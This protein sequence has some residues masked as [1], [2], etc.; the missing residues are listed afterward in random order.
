MK[1]QITHN[2]FIVFSA[3][4]FSMLFGYGASALVAAQY[5]SAPEVDAFFIALPLPMIIGYFILSVALVALVPHYQRLSSELG[6]HQAQR[7]IAPLFWASALLTL[8]ISV[9]LFFTGE[10]VATALAPGF[11]TQRHQLLAGYLQ[12]MSL[13][14]PFLALSAFLQAIENANNRFLR[15]AFARPLASG[16]ALGVL[17][18][19]LM[20]ASL[21]Y[22]FWGLAAGAACAF[23]WQLKEAYRF[24]YMPV[25]LVGLPE[26]WRAVRGSAGW[27]ALARAMAHASG[28]VLQMIASLAV[29]GTVAVYGFGFKIAAIPLLLSVSL[30]MVLFP[31]QTLANAERN[32]RQAANILW[33]GVNSLFILGALFGSFFFLW[34]D[35][36]VILFYE[37][38]DFDPAL[39]ESVASVIR[40]FSLGFVAV[41]ANNTIGNAFWAAGRLK[42]R[43]ALEVVGLG[44]L[45]IG[46]LALIES[47]GPVGLALAYIAMFTFL[48][49]IGLWRLNPE[50]GELAR[51]LPTL[52]KISLTAVALALAASPAT[53]SPADF[54]ELDLF[55]R[56]G[57]IGGSFVG[58][59]VA[60][61]LALWVMRVSE[62]RE[63]IARL[64]DMAAKLKRGGTPGDAAQPPETAPETQSVSVSEPE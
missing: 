60:F 4:I 43:I 54:R 52:L 18:L 3:N 10:S 49:V 17:T 39:T 32:Q 55:Y 13:A 8:M 62:V 59:T 51:R 25:S 34:A 23:F 21:T 45:L 63:A 36:L 12:I 42:E 29:A 48:F 11:D 41:A 35:Q 47:H 5:G 27:I 19:F 61:L 57:V 22:Y 28:I 6:L 31:A 33:R 16:M 26:I 58:F 46:A 38:G 14:M 30:A 2:T 9:L 1:H 53:L 44:I 50:T 37:R 15:A 7:K 64:R 20:E 56:L 40:I 24:G